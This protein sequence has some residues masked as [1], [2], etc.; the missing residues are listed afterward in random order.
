MSDV[1]VNAPVPL[2]P[3]SDPNHLGHA[4]GG[5]HESRA[6]GRGTGGPAPKRIVVGYGFWV[7]ILS[8]IIMFAALFAAYAVLRDGI[9]DGPRGRDIFDLDTVAIE[10]GCLL[11]LLLSV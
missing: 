4:D 8:D 2:R 1:A 11:L 3:R 9:A 10:T 7:F 6:P 5:R